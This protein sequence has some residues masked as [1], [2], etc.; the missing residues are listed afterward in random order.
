MNSERQMTTARK[1]RG[2]HRSEIRSDVDKSE[3]I[4]DARMGLA[5][6]KRGEMV[7]QNTS[8]SRSYM[9]QASFSLRVGVRLVCILVMLSATQTPVNAS[10][11]SSELVGRRISGT[12][13]RG[14]RNGGGTQAQFSYPASVSFSPSGDE[15]V[16]AGCD[17]GTRRIF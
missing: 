3:N 13:K 7:M 8:E 5:R 14:Y 2:I 15:L 10:L 12:G 11:C 4:S 6:R 1:S 17:Y 9:S 16:V